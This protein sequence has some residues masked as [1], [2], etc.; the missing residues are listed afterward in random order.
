MDKEQSYFVEDF[1]HSF[2][3]LSVHFKQSLDDLAKQ[4]SGKN[5][6]EQISS[7]ID[8]IFNKN[9][10]VGLTQMQKTVANQNNIDWL[11]NNKSLETIN[12]SIKEDIVVSNSVI[13]NRSLDILKEQ[14]YDMTE[15]ISAQLTAT[16]HK[17]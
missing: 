14:K 15:S 16:Q 11:I 5:L 13:N 6:S 2:Q 1:S 12:K 7:T 17:L 10:S 9:E 4:F 3:T 8:T